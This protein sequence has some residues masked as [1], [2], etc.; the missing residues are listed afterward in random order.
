[1]EGSTYPIHV[2][3][4][5]KPD[6]QQRRAEGDRWVSLRSLR[7]QPHVLAELDSPKAAPPQ[8]ESFPSRPD[9]RSLYLSVV[10][11]HEQARK[12]LQTAARESM[13]TGISGGEDGE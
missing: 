1:M 11:Q 13:P 12:R 4:I 8:P 5:E 10:K 2:G 3:R 7:S 6:I 9:T